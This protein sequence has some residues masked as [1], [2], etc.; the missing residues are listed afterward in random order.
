MV[1]PLSYHHWLGLNN[2]FYNVIDD[3]GADGCTIWVQDDRYYLRKTFSDDI[4]S[5]PMPVVAVLEPTT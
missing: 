3:V 2:N 1:Q 4:F 5:L